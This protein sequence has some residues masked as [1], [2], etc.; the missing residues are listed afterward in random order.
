MPSGS[1]SWP[2]SERSG[3][4]TTRVASM[5]AETG[6]PVVVLQGVRGSNPLS[7][8]ITAG[9]RPFLRMEK[10]PF[11]L[12]VARKWTQTQTISRHLCWSQAV[13]SAIAPVGAWGS[14]R[15]LRRSTA[16][17]TR[18]PGREQTSSDGRS[19]WQLHAGH[20][21][22]PAHLARAGRPREQRCLSRRR[23]AM[24]RCRPGGGDRLRGRHRCTPW[25]VS[26][27]RK[28]PGEG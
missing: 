25:S 2:R 21:A 8:T 13:R 28:V 15:C 20:Q 18:I 7:S 4:E 16:F 5:H 6:D 3:A 22:R 24:H 9:Q 1:R 19:W 12:S 11:C 26:G 14:S 10:R 23:R 27:H 17:E